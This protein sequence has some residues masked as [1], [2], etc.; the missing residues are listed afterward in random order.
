VSPILSEPMRD[1]TATDATPW[2]RSRTAAFFDA[3]AAAQQ[4][5]LFLH[6]LTGWPRSGFLGAVFPG[7][8][9]VHV[10]RDGR[11][12]ASSWLQMPWWRGYRGPSHWQFGSLSPDD[13]QVWDRSGRSFV[14]LAGLAWRT[15]VGSFELAR[16]AA[17][18]GSWLDVRYEDV[19]ADPRGTHRQMAEHL[20]LPW[21]SSFEAQLSRYHF[22]RGRA[23]AYRSDLDH[24]SAALLED[25]LA[26]P[27]AR[28]G[29]GT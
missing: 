3:R 7:S 23:E 1:L 5:P 15:L 11:A 14:V 28:W 24:R 6:K 18:A 29:Y 22:S 26:E 8:Q 21:T 19:I 16:A 25:C 13:Q 4:R 27:L 20:G 2:L 9:F 12:V 17:P 10:V